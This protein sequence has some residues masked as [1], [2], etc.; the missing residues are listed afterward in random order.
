MDT[1]VK[2]KGAKK[3]SLAQSRQGDSG[4]EAEAAIRSSK[5][6]KRAKRAEQEEGRDA[7]G[8][9]SS[10]M[11]E[12]GR[13]EA[14]AGGSSA[15]D[16]DQTAHG[17]Q[18]G[19]LYARAVET[20]VEYG[21]GRRGLPTTVGGR[22]PAA[23]IRG[24]LD[25]GNEPMT[26][27]YQPL[28]SGGW[29]A[30]MPTRT[31]RDDPL[32]REFNGAGGTPPGT[33]GRDDDGAGQLPRDQG[34]FTWRRETTP[35]P[36]ADQ[37]VWT[38]TQPKP[39]ARIMYDADV[40]YGASSDFALE[41]AHVGVDAC[42]YAECALDHAARLVESGRVSDADVVLENAAGRIEFVPG[43][44]YVREYMNEVYL[45]MCIE[46]TTGQL[47][48]RQPR[49]A[50][51]RWREAVFSEVRN[52][53]YHSDELWVRV[54]EN[55]TPEQRDELGRAYLAAAEARDPVVAATYAE[56]A[57]KHVE[58]NRRIDEYDAMVRR[59]REEAAARRAKMEDRLLRQAWNARERA[60]A[61]LN[62]WRRDDPNAAE[63]ARLRIRR[64]YLK[65]APVEWPMS[66]RGGAAGG[67][68]PRPGAGGH[69]G[70]GN[71]ANGANG[72]KGANGANGA[73]DANGASG[74]SDAAGAGGAGSAAA[75]T[76]GTDGL[77]NTTSTQPSGASA[78]DASGTGT[79]TK[80]TRGEQLNI[81]NRMELPDCELGALRLWSSHGAVIM[82][83]PDPWMEL[84]QALESQRNYPLDWTT[85]VTA[86][87]QRMF[88]STANGAR[89]TNSFARVG[90]LAHLLG[91][92][93]AA[94]SPE[95]LRTAVHGM[96]SAS[97]RSAIA[98]VVAGRAAY[99]KQA[100]KERVEAYASRLMEV[101]RR[102]CEYYQPTMSLKDLASTFAN[103]LYS[104]GV[105]VRARRMYNESAEQLGAEELWAQVR[106]TASR[107]AEEQER[108]ES[109]LHAMREE[110][111]VRRTRP[112]P[113]QV[114][115]ADYE[116]SEDIEVSA[117]R[118]GYAVG[119][120]GR[121][122]AAAGDPRAGTRTERETIPVTRGKIGS[123]ALQKIKC[124]RCGQLGHVRANCQGTERPVQSPNPTK[125]TRGGAV[126]RGGRGGSQPRKTGYC[127]RCGGIG[128][129][130]E[131]CRTV[132]T[133]DTD[134]ERRKLRAANRYLQD[135]GLAP[136]QG[137]GGGPT[138]SP[139]LQGNS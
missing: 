115:A 130:A 53:A 14:Q 5:K 96:V 3:R 126:G 26:R 101:Y 20:S 36:G 93:E 73:K 104:T 56:A 84:R 39:R 16:V 111:P 13:E 78:S 103:G 88:L 11:Q 106:R 95:T 67:G 37:I 77:G 114:A 55:L 38:L 109:E 58:C 76:E 127:T 82:C 65:D 125:G 86:L 24:L 99:A 21:G 1:P 8:G 6:A 113:V 132:A 128:H 30:Q 27:G 51:D 110:I 41:D 12:D 69:S 118:D 108:E 45:R 33:P 74:A 90:T 122:V 79:G 80:L 57:G 105:R 43:E 70:P 4:A 10:A 137:R 81:I 139:T 9:D 31:P 29:R 28:R 34:G 52:A 46:V 44:W 123:E 112:A 75:R 71:G 22:T 100:A 133:D 32:R 25:K 136:V 61:D 23:I 17:L 85:L 68:P 97:Y 64:A 40:E 66:T 49:D 54:Q 72:A 63:E 119:Y 19:D 134:L 131:E 59:L 94:A 120:G 50:F 92:A 60:W 62:K 83:E 121:G 117:L 107:V 7:E 89:G 2:K 47:R 87:R 124:F 116:D 135:L 129:N 138:P 98:D 18:A 42:L 102:Y 91:N 15:N 35:D 48:G